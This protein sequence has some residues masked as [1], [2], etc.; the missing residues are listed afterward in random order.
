MYTVHRATK[1]TEICLD[2]LR[3]PTQ[4]KRRREKTHSHLTECESCKNK[5]RLLSIQSQQHRTS[6]SKHRF[7]SRCLLSIAL[8][9][10]PIQSVNMFL[11]DQFLI[12]NTTSH[13]QTSIQKNPNVSLITTF[14]LLR[15]RT[16]S[17]HSLSYVAFCLHIACFASAPCHGPFIARSTWLSHSIKVS[18][19]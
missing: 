11:H 12:I 10:F 3:S 9:S 19:S 17:A 8:I 2:D 13:T 14:A 1:I 5:T 18:L 15:A 4:G 7:R 6:H 16:A